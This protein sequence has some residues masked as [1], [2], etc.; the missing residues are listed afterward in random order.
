MKK[1]AVL[2]TVAVAL[3]VVS[4]AFARDKS[5]M[6]LKVGDEVYACN[7]GEK[8]P[9]NTMSTNA[10]NCT[11]GKPMVKAKVEKVEGGRTHPLAHRI[12]KARALVIDA[13]QV[14]AVFGERHHR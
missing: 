11:C 3:V 2:L 10:G 8:C 6:E 7:C 13:V 1:I 9:C 12:Q 14:T 4:L 5:K